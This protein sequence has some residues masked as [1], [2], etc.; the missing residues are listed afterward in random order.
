MQT[1]APMERASTFST[2]EVMPIARNKK[3]VSM[4]V[5]TVMPEMGLDDEPISPVKRDETVTKRKPNSTTR[6]APKMA[7]PQLISSPRYQVRMTMSARQP[8]S[9]TFIDK[10]SS[11]R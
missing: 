8:K 1:T 11:V 4:S 7:E 5:A 2:G 9:T 6:T 10:S 3:Q